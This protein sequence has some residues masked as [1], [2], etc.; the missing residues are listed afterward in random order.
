MATDLTV[1]R[2]S[3]NTADIAADFLVD[4]AAEGCNKANLA[5]TSAVV[6]GPGKI[7]VVYTYG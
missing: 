4:L 1:S 3:T 6:L 7:L 2:F 5:T